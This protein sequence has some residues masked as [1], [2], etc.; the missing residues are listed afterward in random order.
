M[1]R[2]PSKVTMCPYSVS[3]WTPL[4]RPESSALAGRA[5][6]LGAG[7]CRP[8]LL[9]ALGEDLSARSLGR[10]CLDWLGRVGL[11]RFGRRFRRGFVI[12]LRR[13]QLHR[14]R[15]RRLDGFRYGLRGRLLDGATVLLLGG[16]DRL[17]RRQVGGPGDDLPPIHDPERAEAT[18]DGH[19]L[20]RL[21]TLTA[22]GN[23]L[24]GGG[25]GY[26]LDVEAILLPAVEVA[27]HPPLDLVA[28]PDEFPIDARGAFVPTYVRP[29]ES[30]RDLA[31]AVAVG[32]ERN[33]DQLERGWHRATVFRTCRR[34]PSPGKWSMAP[35]VYSTRKWP[36]ERSASRAAL[37][38]P[39][40]CPTTP[41]GKRRRGRSSRTGRRHS[42]TAPAAAIPGSASGSPISMACSP[43]RS[44]SPTGRWRRRPSSS[45]TSS[46]PATG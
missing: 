4:P 3:T 43:S 17:P 31:V 33:L 36:N 32:L 11:D 42:A 44:W 26:V 5:A 46:R 14:L 22:D 7:A 23:D 10:R 2:S 8:L 37:Q 45:G 21:A 28:P 30:D 38:A 39:T 15:R 40:S 12:R 9:L 29:G 27:A 25:L 1:Q 35:F 24:L 34:P 18:V 16:A 41:Y 19:A 6:E 20:L 13:C